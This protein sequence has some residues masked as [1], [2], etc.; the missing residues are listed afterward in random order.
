MYT[1]EWVRRAEGEEAKALYD[2]WRSGCAQV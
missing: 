1:H 2:L